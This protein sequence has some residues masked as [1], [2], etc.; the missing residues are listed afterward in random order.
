M[1]KQL[2]V[3]PSLCIGCRTC[4]LACSLTHQ[5]NNKPGR[6][7]I[8]PLGVGK[9]CWVPIV[10][11]QCD[12]PACVKSCLVDALTLDEETGYINLSYEKCIK[13]RACVAA[14]PFGCSLIDE[15]QDRIV[16]CDLCE[17]NPACARFCPT[18]A[19]EYK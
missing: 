11:L 1:T 2:L 13:C 12:D 5:E 3:A 9:E 7:R 10:C 4:E 15:D 17:G 18:K 14:C 8:Y 19:L 16:K 6:S